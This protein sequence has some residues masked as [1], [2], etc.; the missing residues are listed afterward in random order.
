MSNEAIKKI[1]SS[2]S[3]VASGQGSQS[4]VSTVVAGSQS[5]FAYTCPKCSQK[6]ETK[7]E[8][9]IT[10]NMGSSMANT[11]VSTG[12]ST[13][14][15]RLFSF[16]PIIGSIFAQSASEVAKAAVKP[17]DVLEKS[18]EKG[19]EEV[20]NIFAICTKCNEYGCTSCMKDG[21]CSGCAAKPA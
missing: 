17:A 1:I 9:A 19:F 18:R 11:A 20:K 15:S 12:I 8:Y 4:A 21:V 5:R 7:N 6:H 13:F 16:I 10:A 14:F 3:P 2:G